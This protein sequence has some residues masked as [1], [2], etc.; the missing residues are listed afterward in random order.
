[1]ALET[2]ESNVPYPIHLGGDV[3]HQAANIRWLL[4]G[5]FMRLPRYIGADR[6][7]QFAPIPVE[8]PAGAVV[9]SFSWHGDEKSFGAHPE[10][11]Y[12]QRKNAYAMAFWL[13]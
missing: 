4:D 11:I 7:D 12:S 13:H 9:G 8:R 1:M 10:G 6:A 3:W 2:L 5:Q